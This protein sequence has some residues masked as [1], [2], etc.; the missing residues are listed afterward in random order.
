[1]H[2]TNFKTPLLLIFIALFVVMKVH[3]QPMPFDQHTADSISKQLPLAKDD[4]SKVKGLIVLARMYLTNAD[5]TNATKYAGQADS[6][7]TKLNYTLGRIESL[8]QMCFVHAS[9]EDWPRSIMELN[10]AILLCKNEHQDK[11]IYL[12]S[13]MFVNYALKGDMKEAK[14]WALK[15]VRLPFFQSSE[16]LHKWATHMQLGRVYDW[17]GKLDS[18]QYYAD[19]I[20][21]YAAKSPQPDVRDNSFYLLG[22]IATRRKQYDEAIQYYRRGGLQCILGLAQAY[23][24]QNRSD[25]AIYYAKEVL[26]SA[27]QANSHWMILESSKLL[28]R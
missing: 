13:I 5:W 9:T 25:S 2:R 6:I 4:T 16:E 22:T 15:A 14:T 3:A 12:Y 19:L 20:K 7:S 18:A 8:G 28:S 24:Q 27:R 11:L 10:E 1:M 26:D 23:H 21:N 17:E